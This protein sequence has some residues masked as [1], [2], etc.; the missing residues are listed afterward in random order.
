[1]SGHAAA[2]G[3]VAWPAPGRLPIRA[4]QLIRLCAISAQESANPE[5]PAQTRCQPAAH[6]QGMT[7]HRRR[8]R[9][10]GGW[11][12]TRCN[13]PCASVR[14]KMG[15]SSQLDLLHPGAADRAQRHPGIPAV[16]RMRTL[17]QL[18]RPRVREFSGRPAG[19]RKP[20]V[21]IMLGSARRSA[22]LC[23]CVSQVPPTPGRARLHGALP[24]ER[25]DF[26]TSPHPSPPALGFL[27]RSSA[28]F[29]CAACSSS[30]VFCKPI[31]RALQALDLPVGGV[32]LLLM[33]GAKFRD[34]LHQEIDIALQAAGAPL[35]G[36]FGGADFDAGN[37]LRVGAAPAAAWTPEPTTPTRRSGQSLKS[38]C[39]NML[40]HQRSICREWNRATTTIPH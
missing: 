13:Q 24:A 16:L 27:L 7:T 30:T 37:V 15:R 22:H 33:V 3:S 29:F 23:R 17:A 35:H 8:C 26:L 40:G 9:I 28:A 25:R 34:R 4:R 21:V 11:I 31:T 39:S 10:G 18:P 14:D 1:M 36:L 5:R 2:Q 6:R 38:S 12:A 19:V 32:E 20:A